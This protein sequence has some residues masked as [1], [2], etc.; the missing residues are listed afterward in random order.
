MAC[1]AALAGI[2]L[3]GAAAARCVLLTQ[4]P[5]ALVGDF[6]IALLLCGVATVLALTA[7]PFTGVFLGEQR[8]HVPALIVLVGRAAQCALL[9]VAAVGFGTIEALAIAYCLGQ[10]LTTGGQFVAW[11][12]SGGVRLLGRRASASHYRELWHFC[13]PFVLWNSLAA[14]SFGSDL[15]IVS[16]VDFS[17]TPYYA[18]SLTI[19]T[20]F[21]R[22]SPRATT[23]C[24]RLRLATSAPAIVARCSACCGEA[25]AWVS[26][27]RSRSACRSCSPRPARSRFG[28]ARR[29]PRPRL[30]TWRC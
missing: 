10:V 9:V 18:V 12:A 28:S 23:R 25:A 26:V 13:S 21:V 19:A 20:T 16:K 7:M 17:A 24:C 15:L 29:M 2:V 22:L 3:V 1:A 14:L 8:A 4:M 27:F 5:G 11:S 30:H 6:R